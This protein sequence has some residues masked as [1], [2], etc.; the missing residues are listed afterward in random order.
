LLDFINQDKVLFT[1]AIM[2]F[3]G[4]TTKNV[5]Y[6][7]RY[8]MDKT[9]TLPT[10]APP[11]VALI[12]GGAKRLGKQIVR[13]LHKHHYNVIIHCNRSI[14]AA[15]QLAATL[16]TQR[17]NSAKVVCG[18]ITNDDTVKKMVVQAIDCYG[19]LDLLVNNASSFYST[20][21]NPPDSAAFND[22]TG[23]NMKAP[24]LLSC[25]FSPYLS[26]TQGNIVNLVDIHADKPLKAHTVY[27]MAKAGLNMMIKSLACELAPRIR[28]NGISPGAILWPEQSISTGEKASIVSQVALQR[29]GEP[30]DIAN[31]VLFLANAPYITGQTIV[32]DGG[33]SL[34][35]A[36]IA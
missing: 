5:I 12:T 7:N 31:T 26:K 27:S 14:E 9:A 11:K 30:V 18:D 2:V 23:T 8:S 32:V 4:Y 28:V 17:D 3:C 20:K 34:L 22:L 24:Y 21:I 36:N 6:K 29:L 1:L 35:G 13:T 16:N 33:R 10:K 19:Q 15:E 25:L